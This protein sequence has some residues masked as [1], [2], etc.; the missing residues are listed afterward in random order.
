MGNVIAVTGWNSP[1]YHLYGRNFAAT[2]AE[3]WPQDYAL[4][5]YTEESVKL[6]RGECRSLWDC[7]GVADFIAHYKD[8]AECCG[9]RENRLWGRRAIGKPYNFRFDAVKFCRQMFIPSHAA[10]LAQPDDIIVWL[11]GDVVTDR[12]VPPR[13]IE[14][15]LGD[16]DLVYLG[17]A[18]TH[19][20]IGFWACRNNPRGRAFMDSLAEMY[21][22]GRVFELL[23]WHSAW[24]FDHVRMDMEAQ[25]RD[26]LIAY[27]L[28][29]NG[30]DHVW[31]Q[32]PLGAF[33]DH[34]KGDT[35]KRKGASPERSL[36]PKPRA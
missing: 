22:S 30:S 18:R 15:T 34:L 3:F 17:R 29:P 36:A 24:V 6:P 28:T 31:F 12:R 19:S 10:S 27:N 35:R 2:F 32:S 1:G 25:K 7:P 21:R 20:E 4:R 23:E 33:S 5:A 8:N 26:P 16:A 13:F 14:T 11:D 9:R